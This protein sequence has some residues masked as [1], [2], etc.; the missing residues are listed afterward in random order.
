M[1]T[2]PRHLKPQHTLKYCVYYGKDRDHYLKEVQTFDL[3]ITTYAL[4]RL[5]WKQRPSTGE[6][7][8]TLHTIRWDRVVLDEGTRSTASISR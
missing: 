7:N 3:V 1:L 5:D 8:A 4:V 2:K 6:G